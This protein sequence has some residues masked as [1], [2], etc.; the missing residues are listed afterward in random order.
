MKDTKIAS[1]SLVAAVF[2]AIGASLCCVLPLVLVVLGIGGAWVSTLTHFEFLRP[3]AITITLLCLG[4]AF[5][6]LYVTPRSCAADRPC[7]HPKVIKRQRII[8]W[9][10]TLLIMML[11]TFPWIAPL[12]Y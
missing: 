5:W 11:I 8:F 1:G 10:V 12:F 4:I 3:V 7:V 2:A 6:K 9:T